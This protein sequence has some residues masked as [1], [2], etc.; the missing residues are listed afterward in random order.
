MQPNRDSKV[1]LGRY[2]R[3]CR[4]SF[5]PKGRNVSYLLSYYA[6]V[7]GRHYC[8]LAADGDHILSALLTPRELEAFISMC[9]KLDPETKVQ[10]LASPSGTR[11]A[12]A[13]RSAPTSRAET[14]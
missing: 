3:T 2:P 11:K 7:G 4:Y 8:R 1:I 6:A 5:R 10:Q 14:S 9:R 13:A 12:R